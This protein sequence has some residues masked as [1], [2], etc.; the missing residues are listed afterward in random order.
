ML[1]DL[2]PVAQEQLALGPGDEPLPE[3][4]WLKE[5]LEKEQERKTPADTTDWR[6]L[7]VAR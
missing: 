2:R 1:L 4:G 6:G 3:R 7:V 5:V